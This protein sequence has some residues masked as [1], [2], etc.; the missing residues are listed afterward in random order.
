MN[1]CRGIYSIQEWQRMS[2]SQMDLSPFR[3]LCYCIL[4]LSHGT[5]HFVE[6]TEFF[7]EKQVV[8]NVRVLDGFIIPCYT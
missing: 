4:S 1:N 2:R 7:V 5:G 3:C 8:V 6:T